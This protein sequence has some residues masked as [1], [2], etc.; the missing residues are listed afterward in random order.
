MS[1]HDFD[2]LCGLSVDVEAGVAGGGGEYLVATGFGWT[3][4]VILKM[5]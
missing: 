4:D 1:G 3:N 2:A 5:F